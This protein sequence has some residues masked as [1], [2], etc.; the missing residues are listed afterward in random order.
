MENLVTKE[1][2][3]LLRFN[4]RQS[5]AT[6]YKSHILGVKVSLAWHVYA[7]TL[8][9]VTKTSKGMVPPIPQE[10]WEWKFP[11]MKLGDITKF[12]G[13]GGYWAGGNMSVLK[14]QLYKNCLN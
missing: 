7:C 1:P 11:R 8:L 13:D 12:L 10:M 2:S 14:V 9:G 4:Y 6:Q 3:E 5:W